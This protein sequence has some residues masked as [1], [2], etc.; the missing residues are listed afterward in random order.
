VTASLLTRDWSHASNMVQVPTFAH[1]R[2]RTTR[3]AYLVRTCH[4]FTLKL[5][6][7]HTPPRADAWSDGQLF[8]SE[9]TATLLFLKWPALRN[10]ITAL[11][12]D[13]TVRGATLATCF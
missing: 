9:T 4:L 13:D 11:R 1:T 12:W 2:T 10:R 8:C 3:P 6:R 7:S 5:A